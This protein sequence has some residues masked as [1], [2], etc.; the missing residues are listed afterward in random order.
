MRVA[1][2]LSLSVAVGSL[3]FRRA[4]EQTAPLIG[5]SQWPADMYWRLGVVQLV[6]H[7]L[8]PEDPQIAGEHLAYH[9]FSAADMAAASL[10]TGLDPRLVLSRLWVLPV[11]ALTVAML[12]ATLREIAPRRRRRGPPW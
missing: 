9:W 5:T 11:V 10:A 6:T 1:W 7:Q 4:F 3:G 12:L 2:M 8:R